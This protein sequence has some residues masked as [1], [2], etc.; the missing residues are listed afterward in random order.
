MMAVVGADRSR[1]ESH[2]SRLREQQK[3]HHRAQRL[4]ALSARMVNMREG[5]L[6]IRVEDGSPVSIRAAKLLADGVTIQL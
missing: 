4:V 6:L 3:Q 5:W 2:V 1:I